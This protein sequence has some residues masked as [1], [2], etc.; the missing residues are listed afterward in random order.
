MDIALRGIIGE[1]VVVSLSDVIVFSKDKRDHIAH[2]RK[3]FNICRR[4]GIS[5][6][7][8]KSIFVVDEGKPLG[9]IVSKNDVMIEPERIETISKI[10]FPHNMKSMQTFLRKINFIRRF[11]KVLLKLSS[12]SKI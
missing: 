11:V 4:Y 5:L 12:P 7:P 10:L 9:F 1:Y 6:N 3:I 8:K 2:L